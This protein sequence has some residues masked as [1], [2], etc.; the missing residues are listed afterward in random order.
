[1]KYTYTQD[2]TNG[3]LDRLWTT[4]YPLGYEMNCENILQLTNQ[5][6]GAVVFIV[7]CYDGRM[8]IGIRLITEW[9]CGEVEDWS[10]ELL[11][12]NRKSMMSHAYNL[13]IWLILNKL[14]RSFPV[15]H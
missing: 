10:Q 9:I 5:D 2:Q 11:K 6:N 15:K 1:M 8:I 3:F 12:M 7:K 4:A 13:C 14:I